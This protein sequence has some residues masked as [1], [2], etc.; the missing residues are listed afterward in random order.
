[1]AL[2]LPHT[3]KM[4]KKTP[5]NDPE[6]RIRMLSARSQP[7]YRSFDQVPVPKLPL[8][9]TQTFYEF[10]E[11]STDKSDLGKI[12]L[13]LPTGRTSTKGDDNF[14]DYLET[15][16][17]NI[18]TLTHGVNL[19]FDNWTNTLDEEESVQDTDTVYSIVTQRNRD[20]QL[21]EY[22]KA[23]TR[24]T[25]TDGQKPQA[26]LFENH[27][28]S[29]SGDLRQMYESRKLSENE[30]IALTTPVDQMPTYQKTS[31]EIDDK[32]I[33][34]L[35]KLYEKDRRLFKQRIKRLKSG[36]DAN[37][38]E[39]EE[40]K[41][42][43]VDNDAK[44]SS[45]RFSARLKRKTLEDYIKE[46]K[47]TAWKSDEFV[48]RIKQYKQ[49]EKEE[50]A[51]R[52]NHIQQHVDLFATNCLDEE[53]HY[54]SQSEQ[55]SRKTQHFEMAKEKSKQVYEKWISLD[56]EKTNT[57]LEKYRKSEERQQKALLDRE[58]RPFREL[59][60]KRSRGWI[61][62]IVLAKFIN[63]ADKIMLASRG[64]R[65][66][67]EK[68]RLA[69]LTLS[70]LMVPLIHRRRERKSKLAQR[71]I[72]RNIFPWYMS[73]RIKLKRRAIATVVAYIND[74]KESNLVTNRVS[75]YMRQG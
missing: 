17:Y 28:T 64:D 49:Q 22:K 31:H 75:H 68:R 2:I 55:M 45:M 33:D 53:K 42:Q 46:I 35:I 5:R 74:L 38:E 18:S 23:S 1:M 24:G 60:T 13:Q 54:F 27:M 26:T 47:N 32:E 30:I 65:D 11:F 9:S 19:V 8:T 48:K 40:E 69:M 21:A 12:D 62:A 56:D 70:R 34:N 72:I 61:P 10:N 43:Y 7:S 25:R 66:D 4:P 37:D 71:V 73:V 36:Q 15:K 50:K 59:M 51:K 67:I 41:K 29:I 14:S 6:D 3:P 58:L 39:F 20:Q 52:M 16:A 63:R 44:K 57:L